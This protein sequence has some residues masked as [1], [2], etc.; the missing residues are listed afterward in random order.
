MASSPSF[1]NYIKGFHD[2]LS[3]IDTAQLS[4]SPYAKRYLQHLLQNSHYYLSIYAHVLN[5]A[6]EDTTS[7]YKEMLLVDYGAGNG[8]LGLFAKY[9]GF[10]KVMLCD[11][12]A[13]FMEAAKE[14]ASNLQIDAEGFVSGDLQTLLQQYPGTVPHVVVGTD[15]IEHI[16]NLEEFFYELQQM[17]PNMI[18]VFTTASNPENWIKKAALEKLQTKDETVGGDP[19]D[20]ALAGAEKHAAYLQMREDIIRTNFPQ[21]KEAL[22]NKLAIATRGL[23]KP[24][25][26]AAVNEFLKDGSLPTL[27]ERKNTCHPLTGSWTE[28]ILPI[29]RYQKIY[30][31]AGFDL[32]IYNGFY[33]AYAV[34]LKKTINKMLNVTIPIAGRKIA[35]FITLKGRP[36]L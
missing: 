29:S 31:A 8:L 15:V 33:N 19:T 27:P 35:P 7:S 6:I 26:I 10:K 14:L 28:R 30:K 23:Y 24:D 20:F 21:L 2:K 16:Y 36:T 11:V 18:T 12:D 4:G 17:N 25:I 22:A 34:G 5:H 3:R 32:T 1:Y 9:A 13:T